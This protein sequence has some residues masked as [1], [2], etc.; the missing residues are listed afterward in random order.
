ML[1]VTVGRTAFGNLTVVDEAR[2][3]DTQN[4]F[5]VVGQIGNA[6]TFA[7][8]HAA[9]QA[10]FH[11]GRVLGDR[12]ITIVLGTQQTL[13]FQTHDHQALFRVDGNNLVT[14]LGD[15]AGVFTL[16]APC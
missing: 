3:V 12:Q 11:A 15:N 10:E 4:S 13:A 14:L 5:V 6:L 7:L 16:F 1:D 2:G 9:A 8:A